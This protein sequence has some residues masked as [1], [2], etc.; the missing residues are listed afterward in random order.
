VSEFLCL[1]GT[2]VASS[3]TNGG[4]P[5]VLGPWY[6]IIAGIGLILGAIY[7]LY[8]IGAVVFG[9]ENIPDHGD[10]HPHHNLSVDLNAREIATLVPIALICFFIGLYPSP[11]LRAVEPAAAHM[12]AGYGQTAMDERTSSEMTST[13]E[14]TV[15]VQTSASIPTTD[16]KELARGDG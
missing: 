5:G 12:L 1:L 9:Q 4:Y 11:I 2:F 8:L 10:E 14:G 13:V 15:F 16:R 3:P 7:M 6:G